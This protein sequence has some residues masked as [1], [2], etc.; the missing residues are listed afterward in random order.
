VVSL[1]IYIEKVHKKKNC[2][3]TQPREHRRKKQKLLSV[4]L[5]QSRKRLLLVRLHSIGL[6]RSFIQE[7][8]LPSM[9]VWQASVEDEIVSLLPN[10][11]SS[12]HEDFSEERSRKLLLCIKHHDVRIKA[13]VLIEGTSEEQMKS[14]FFPIF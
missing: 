7:T 14:S 3:K 1:L 6:Q 8:S 4:Q 13:E 12:Y 5:K 11:P 9:E 2:T 10:H